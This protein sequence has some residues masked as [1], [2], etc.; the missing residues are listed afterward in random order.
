[1]KLFKIFKKETKEVSK[2]NLQK[3]DKNQLNQVIGGAGDSTS[4][5]AGGPLKGIDVKLGK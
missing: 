3:L 5:V 2:S 1:M 4:T